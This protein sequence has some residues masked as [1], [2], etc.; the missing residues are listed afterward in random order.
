MILFHLQIIEKRRTEF[1]SLRKFIPAPYEIIAYSF[2]ILAYFILIQLP[3]YYPILETFKQALHSFW[4]LLF[5]ALV[6]LIL[7]V[8]IRLRFRK[9]TVKD[10]KTHL[11]ESNFSNLNYWLEAVRISIAILVA[12]VFHFLL[13]SSVFLINPRVWDSEL[14]HL[15]QMIHFGISPSLFFLELFKSEYFYRGI[16][17]FYSIIYGG[18]VILYPPIFIGIASRHVRRVLGT[19]FILIFV[20]GVIV[21]IAI[22]SWGPVFVEPEEFESALQQMP[23]TVKVQSQLYKETSSLVR[24]P[25][26]TRTIVYGGI[27][28][29][30][31]LHVAI[32]TLFALISHTVSKTWFKI[33]VLFVIFM[34]LGSVVTGYHYLIDGYA[35]LLL[36]WGTYKLADLWEN[37]LESRGKEDLSTSKN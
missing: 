11:R 14:Q 4:R 25:L 23:M 1:E 8:A 16:D 18:L 21:Y 27:A 19:A 30:P 24:N 34:I 35:G 2:G 12:M 15:D 13:K 33:N 28:A 36:G 3:V 20:I 32:L 10:W 26:G 5:L 9:E 17:Y 6:T 31:S 22:P 7:S 29:F 37:L